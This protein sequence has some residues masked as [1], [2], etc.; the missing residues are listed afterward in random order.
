MQ[1]SDI[2]RVARGSRTFWKMPQMA[3]ASKVQPDE[4]KEAA[5]QV[6]GA[7]AALFLQPLHKVP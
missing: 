4:E 6:R 7:A 5:L 1:L 2:Q 3:E